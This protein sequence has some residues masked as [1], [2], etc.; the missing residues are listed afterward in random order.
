MAIFSFKKNQSLNETSVRLELKLFQII[1]KR[2]K[3]IHFCKI[4]E[5]IVYCKLTCKCKVFINYSLIKAEWFDV[6][7]K[8]MCWMFL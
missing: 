4:T 1:T 5:V 3:K 2:S 6:W 8:H 7:V